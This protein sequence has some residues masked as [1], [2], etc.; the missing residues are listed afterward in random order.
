M[1]TS[2]MLCLCGFPL[3][4]RVGDNQCPNCFK[5]VAWD[6][7][8]FAEADPRTGNPHLDDDYTEAQDGNPEAG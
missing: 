7:G 5:S 8:I 6:G 4:I 3:S 2:N 1:T